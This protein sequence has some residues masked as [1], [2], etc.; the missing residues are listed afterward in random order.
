MS[1]TTIELDRDEESMLA[2]EVSDDA[3]ESAAGVSSGRAVNFSIAMCSGL[4][5]C[6]V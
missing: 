3:L 4:D 2:Y 6:P 1:D 5:T